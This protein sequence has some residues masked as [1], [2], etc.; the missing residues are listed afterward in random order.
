MLFIDLYIIEIFSLVL[1]NYSIYFMVFLYLFVME[2]LCIDFN[3][4]IIL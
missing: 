2:N 3:N 4:D 1:I